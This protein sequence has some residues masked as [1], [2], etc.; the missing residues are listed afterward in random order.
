VL[1]HNEDVEQAKGRSD[2]DEEIA[3]DVGFVSAPDSC[4]GYA[5]R[6]MGA[7]A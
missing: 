1:D 2:R 5:A 6:L 4:A 3:G 7:H